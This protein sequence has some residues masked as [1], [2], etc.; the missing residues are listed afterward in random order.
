MVIGV[1]DNG[2]LCSF[3]NCHQS[4]GKEKKYDCVLCGHQLSDKNSYSRH[5]KIVQE[6]VKFPCGQCNHQATSKG[7]LISHKRAVHQY[8]KESSTLAGIVASNLLVGQISPDIKENYT[9]LVAVQ[10]H[11]KVK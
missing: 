10:F 3:L 11:K 9:L 8:M 4:M 2:L 6:G 1:P 5:K 7:N